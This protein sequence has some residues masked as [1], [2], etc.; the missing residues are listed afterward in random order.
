MIALSV[1]IAS[2]GSSFAQVKCTVWQNSEFSNIDLGLLKSV[3]DASSSAE[4]FEAGIFELG[5]EYFL[6]PLSQALLAYSRLNEGANLIALANSDIATHILSG[7][8][9]CEQKQLQFLLF[10]V[11]RAAIVDPSE[12]MPLSKGDYSLTHGIAD[13]KLG[14]LSHD[15]KRARHCISEFVLSET[16]KL[17]FICEKAIK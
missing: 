15:I 5:Q 14:L 12:G 16:G 9:H 17:E 6:N 11:R 3:A 4:R 8:G 1:I 13:R 7:S 2:A 10:V